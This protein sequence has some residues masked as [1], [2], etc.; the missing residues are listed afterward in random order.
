[1]R[2]GMAQEAPPGEVI[3]DRSRLDEALARGD[4]TVSCRPPWSREP[5]R[6]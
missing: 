5:P 2:G 3:G 1:M 6:R 4:G